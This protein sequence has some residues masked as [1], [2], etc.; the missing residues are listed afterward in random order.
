[1]IND[2]K[3]FVNQNLQFIE[4]LDDLPFPATH[5]LDMENYFKINTPQNPYSKGKRVAQ[6]MTSRGCSA[7]C[8]FCTTTNF[9]G[10][11]FRARSAEN[12]ISEIKHLK[13]N[14]NIDELQFTDD[15]FTINK[16]R[17]VQ[18]L[19]GI[20]EFGLYWCAPQGVAAWTLD[21]ELLEKSVE[22]GCYQLTFGIESGNQEVLRKIVR[23]PLKLDKIKPLVKKSHDLGI[24]VHAFCVCGFPGE[25]ISQMYDTYNFVKNSDFDSAS[26]FVANPLI[27]SDLLKICQE[28]G[29]LKKGE[30]GT[31][32]FKLGNI[33]TPDWTAKEVED[34]VA[35]FNKEY[36]KND[37]RAKHWDKDKY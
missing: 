12:V 9:W 35:Y 22:S 13:E 7:K 1:M 15:N 11:R 32:S 33:S 5:L 27:G 19:D 18:I 28:K 10:N 21:D 6:I 23:K 14:Y 2:N 20:K 8:V 37:T 36:N 30:Y 24:K 16:K 31:T 29:Y 34:L 17:A 25:T 3:S 4:N 26:F